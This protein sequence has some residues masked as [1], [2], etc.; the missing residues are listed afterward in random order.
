MTERRTTVLDTMGQRN[1]LDKF[2]ENGPYYTSYPTLGFWSNDFGHDHYV[3]A[4]ESFFSKEGEDAPLA[5]YIHIPFC[6]RL[7]WYCLCNI[8]ISNNRE[9]IQGFLN[10]LLRE[11][12]MLHDFLK[13]RGITPNIREVH[14]G[15]GTPSHLDNGQFAQLIDKLESLVNIKDSDELAMEIDPRTTNHENL[16]FFS[17]KGVSRISFGVQDFDPDVQKVINRVQPPEMVQALLSPEIRKCFTSV[18]FDLLYGLPLQTRDTFRKTVEIV[19]GLSPERITLL[20]YAHVPDIRKHMKLIK[21]SDL[22]D[23]DE[24]PMMFTESVEAFLD[25][26]YEWVGIDNFAKKSDK[27]A[28]AVRNKTLGRDFNGWTTG[29]AKHLIGLG[30]T[31]TCAFGDYYCQSV[32]STEDYYRSIEAG[33][34]PIL[35]GYRINRDDLIRR[36]V[37]FK[38]LCAQGLRMEETERKYDIEFWEYFGD[39]ISTLNDGF[40]RDGMVELEEDAITITHL[41][42]F[43]VRN[44]CKVFDNFVKDRPYKITGP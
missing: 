24:L 6:A 35:R 5:L 28:T 19:K 36:D 10:Y 3:K 7:C 20:K 41:G 9:R 27:L 25:C 22:P 17:E 31:T 23:A 13:E 4:L 43:F 26:G 38:L 30:P 37:I 39:E 29:K 12:D 42:R 40:V 32:Y 16:K 8:I 1:F 18:N 14:L 33:K 2:N 34:F 11:I 15:G 44:M 21:E